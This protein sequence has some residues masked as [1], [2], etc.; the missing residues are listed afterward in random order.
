MAPSSVAAGLSV[1]TT[2][3][4]LY[5]VALQHAG[6]SEP[7]ECFVRV[8]SHPGREAK[9]RK[10]RNREVR[11]LPSACGFQRSIGYGTRWSSTSTRER[12]N[13]RTP[14]RDRAPISAG[15]SVFAPFP[16]PRARSLGALFRLFPESAHVRQRGIPASE[17]L[18]GERPPLTDL[19]WNERLSWAS[20]SGYFP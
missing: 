8:L 2:S 10:T 15:Q 16:F 7:D 9:H 13:L 4:V 14:D 11:A 20:P 3:G 12:G 1:E 18:S 6:P 17:L 5:R 19:R